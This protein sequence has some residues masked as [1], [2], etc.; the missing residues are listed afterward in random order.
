MPYLPPSCSW[1]CLS[2]AAGR[3]E[4]ASETPCC[5]PRKQ[6]GSLI[7]SAALR[8]AG[9]FPSCAR[10][11]QTPPT[12][13]R[14]SGFWFGLVQIYMNGTE[15][16]PHPR[17]R[18]TEATIATLFRAAPAR[19]VRACQ[20]ISYALSPINYVLGVEDQPKDGG[21]AAR[22][23]VNKFEAEVCGDM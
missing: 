22:R 13:Q 23:F 4:A 20:V 6:V 17:H 12:A 11:P 19:R 5:T 9:R 3:E 1:I 7:A 16:I 10:T 15:S 14:G 8:N 21:A 2:D 18:H